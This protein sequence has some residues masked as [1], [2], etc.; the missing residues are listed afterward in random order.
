MIQPSESSGFLERDQFLGYNKSK[1]KEIQ[2]RI[3]HEWNLIKLG[4]T[5]PENLF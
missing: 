4:M 2:I 3:L 1:W 5:V